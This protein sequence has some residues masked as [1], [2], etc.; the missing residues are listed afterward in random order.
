MFRVYTFRQLE[1][2]FFTPVILGVSLSTGS[3]ICPS[4]KA[5]LTLKAFRGIL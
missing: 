5:V 1:E 2:T 3:D 4:Q